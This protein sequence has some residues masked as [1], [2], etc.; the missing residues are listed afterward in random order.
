MKKETKEKA[1]E[2]EASR[3]RHRQMQVEISLV[4]IRR[5]ETQLFQDPEEAALMGEVT[6]LLKSLRAS[7]RAVSVKKEETGKAASILMEEQPTV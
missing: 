7:I 2:K 6:T 1:K 5:Q 4:A 3:H